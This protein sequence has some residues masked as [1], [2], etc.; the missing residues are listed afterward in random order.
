MLRDIRY[1]LR[2]LA[3]NKG[4]TA[5][6][7]LALALGIG[8]NTAIFSVVW[9]TLLAPLPYPDAD[10]IVVVWLKAKGERG[11]SSSDDYLAYKNQ[12]RSF[13]RL[14]YSPW[15]QLHL[16]SSDRTEDIVGGMSAPGF[17]AMNLRTKM[18]LGRDFLPEEGEPGKD[19]VAI[20][21]HRLWVERYHSD[22][23]IIGKQIQIEEQPYT[24]VGVHLA[25]AEDR[26]STQFAVPFP[27]TSKVHYWGNIF[28]RLKP[29][30]TIAQAQGE[31]AVIDR[32]LLPTRNH[33]FPPNAW[34]VSVEPLKNDWL[35]KNLERNLWLLL[36]SVG[37][38]LLIA[39]VNVANLLLARGIAREKEI[40]VRSSLGASP[41]Q[42]FAQLITESLALAILGGAIGIG[43]GWALMKFVL[44]MLPGN[45]L[46][47]E[48]VVRLNFPVLLFTLGV[49]LLSGVLFGCA[50]AWRASKVDLAEMLKQGARGGGRRTRIQGM[51]VTAEF[52]L[53]LTLLAGAGM[54]LHSFWLLTQID[55][56]VRTD[57]IFTAF[58]SSPKKQFANQEAIVA[59]ARQVMEKVQAVPGVQSVAL[60]T[61][62]PL[63]GHGDF[64]FRIAG[65]PVADA[66]R[67]NADFNIVTPTYFSTFHVRLMR[68]RF[69]T[70][71]DTGGSPQVVVVNESFV[72]RYLQN[73]DPLSQRL[74]IEQ[75]VPYGK[76]GPATERQIVGVYHD[77]SNGEHLSDKPAPAI[78]A[79]FWQNPWPN[80]GLVVRTLIDPK[81]MH[82]NIDNAV[83]AAAP[84]SLLGH[85]GTMD[86]IVSEQ[87]ITDRFGMVLF[88][89]F[90]GLALLLAALGIYGVMA[91]AVAQRSQEIGLRMA[92]GAQ[93]SEVMKLILTGGIKLAS[94]GVVVGIAGAWTLG[95]FLHGTLYGVGTVDV[96]S[97]AAVI[98]L[99]LAAA[100][101][102][103]Y[104]PAKR[105]TR[106]DPMAALREQ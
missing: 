32:R 41:R 42:V 95:H 60:T 65:Q 48:A 101:V 51:L 80:T 93:Q 82:R 104:G 90:A 53:A 45:T 30:V 54:A 12:S 63:T 73:V 59:N 6:A 21:T 2:T 97:F 22:P 75:L 98:F 28:G 44:T 88:A 11:P 34:S 18:A 37:F 10:Q 72:H 17:Y 71:D 43:L 3:K 29:G 50:P 103:C 31:L 92:L 64:P 56:G 86:Q 67:P 100:L 85:V 36:A 46:P 1:G 19:H 87:L 66:N 26:Q 52:A 40:A 23:Q 83:L 27:S 55:T 58:L 89:G 62:L 105:S 33:D 25:G 77:V 13:Q 76:L 57:H 15:V 61:G 5:V 74:L 24:V 38:V 7:I 8:P 91:F 102:A 78:L 14:D 69:L 9:A 99:L 68:G 70:D 47:T 4:F 39:C 96:V 20:I 79:P 49:T 84:S 106:V 16:T 94:L 35:S 81:L